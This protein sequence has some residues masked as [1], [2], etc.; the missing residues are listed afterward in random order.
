MDPPGGHRL[1]LGGLDELVGLGVDVGQP[2][3]VLERA[4][5]L[6]DGVD[7]DHQ[8]AAVGGIADALDDWLT[9]LR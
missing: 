8:Q 9:E 7:L 4:H 3:H 6:L 5:H 2:G 1:R